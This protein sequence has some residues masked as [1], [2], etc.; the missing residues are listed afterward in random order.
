MEHTRGLDV[1]IF[2]ASTMMMKHEYD[3]YT[4]LRQ[5][6][7]SSIYTIFGF[8][9]V[10]KQLLS[11]DCTR[12]EWQK[13]VD[14]VRMIEDNGIHFFASFGIGFD[15]QDRNIVDKILKFSNDAGIDLAEFYILTPFPGTPFGMQ[16]EKENR[17]LHRNYSSWN[18]GNVVFKPVHWTEEELINDFYLLWKEFYNNKNPQ[19]TTR[20]FNLCSLREH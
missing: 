6:G 14:L 10:S 5:G 20:T 2:L 1:K 11:K 12:D 19:E 7:A 13:G 17:I 15:N 4:R 8:D 16:A 18:H 3:F 9:K